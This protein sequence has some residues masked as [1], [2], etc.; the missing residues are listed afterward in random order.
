MAHEQGV[1]VETVAESGNIIIIQGNLRKND[2]FSFKL[3]IKFDMSIITLYDF[4]LY[5]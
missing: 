4:S 3:N 1:E 2:Y 5:D